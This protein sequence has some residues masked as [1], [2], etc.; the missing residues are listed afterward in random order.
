MIIDILFALG[1]ILFTYS[2]IPQIKKLYRY[3]RAD[4]ISLTKQKILAVAISITIVACIISN[5]PISIL[6]NSIQ[7]ILVI[8]TMLQIKRYRN[9]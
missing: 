1:A 5:L 6:V 2:A 7:L 8:I 3:K 9:E 4:D